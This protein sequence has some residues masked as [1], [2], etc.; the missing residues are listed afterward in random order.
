M[1]G[2]RFIVKQVNGHNLKE[3]S[4]AIDYAL[5]RKRLP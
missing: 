5:Q 3:L 1:E 2:V 4:A